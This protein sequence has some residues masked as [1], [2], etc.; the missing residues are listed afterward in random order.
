M[1]HLFVTTEF[2]GY[3]F[4]GGYEKESIKG[5]EKV[6]KVYLPLFF[7]IFAIL[8]LPACSRRTNRSGVMSQE[9]P[10]TVGDIAEIR[11]GEENHQKVLWQHK[12]YNNPTLETYLNVIAA[13]IAEVSTRPS[14]PY[15]VYLLDEEE[16][17]IFGGPGGHIYVTRGFLDFVESESELAGVIAHEIGHISHYDYANIPHFSKMKTIYQGLLKGTDIAKNTIGTYGTAAYYGVKGVGQAAP[18]IAKQFTEDAEV[19]ADE[20]AV[21][22]LVKAG[23]DPRGF[24]RFVDRLAKVPVSDVGRFVMLM[25]THP[26]FPARR[27]LLHDQVQEIPMEEGKI[28]FRKD[29]LNEVRQ[30]LVRENQYQSESILFQPEMGIRRIDPFELNQWQRDKDDKLIPAARKRWEAF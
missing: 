27:R 9:L 17:N 6:K 30:T 10:L 4:K 29:M 18:Q 19:I 25:N 11:N 23:Y 12:L 21:E 24:E 3:S 20:K 1:L 7:L 8:F 13:S 26:P 15:R 14:L 16:V 5:D 28:E 22:I 2:V